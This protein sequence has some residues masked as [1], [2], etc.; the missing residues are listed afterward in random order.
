MNHFGCWADASGYVEHKYEKTAMIDLC[1][2]L[3]WERRENLKRSLTWG[4][5]DSAVFSDLT[6]L[7]VVP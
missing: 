4:K 7:A 6:Q 3:E 1:C 2:E 5:R